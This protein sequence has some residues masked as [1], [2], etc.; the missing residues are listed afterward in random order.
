LKINNI[1][2]IAS[3]ALKA[4]ASNVYTKEEINN[5]NTSLTNNSNSSLTGKADKSDTYNK[6]DMNVS[7]S[8]L[9]ASIDNKVQISTV[10]INSRFKILTSV[11]HNFKIQRKIGAILY[12]SLDLIFNDTDKTSMLKIN[13]IDILASLA[14]KSDASNVYTKQRTQ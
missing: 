10:D 2:I 14:L 6:T 4:V 12:D 7:L 11:D 1:D 13:N 9:Q 5:F 3:L 8:I